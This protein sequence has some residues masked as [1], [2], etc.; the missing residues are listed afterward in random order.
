[1]IGGK[2]IIQRDHRQEFSRI[3]DPNPQIKGVPQVLS[4][5][6]PQLN[7]TMIEL[8]NT[9]AKEENLKSNHREKYNPTKEQK[10][11]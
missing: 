3:D 1:M 2:D 7:L 4:N 6:N 10:P 9:K 11:A 5:T 8:Q